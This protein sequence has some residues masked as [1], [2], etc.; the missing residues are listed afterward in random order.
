M[1]SRRK[2]FYTDVD[3]ER[4]RRFRTKTPEAEAARR[5]AVEE[6]ILMARDRKAAGIEPADDDTPEHK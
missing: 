1:K 2:P 5:R 4:F 6:F 3:L